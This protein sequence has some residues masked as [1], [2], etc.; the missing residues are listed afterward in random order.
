MS[1]N[2]NPKIIFLHNKK[3]KMDHIINFYHYIILANNF[4]EI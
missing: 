2:V 3:Y 1:F 4:K